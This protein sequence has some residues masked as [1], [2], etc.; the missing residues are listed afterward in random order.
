[1][2]TSSITS[3]ESILSSD[4]HDQVKINELQSSVDYSSIDEEIINSS[5][6][7]D[8]FKIII[9]LFKLEYIIN[10]QDI[11]NS[12]KQIE[13]IFT[14]IQ[15]IT[16]LKRI[17][18]SGYNTNNN[19]IE[20]YIKIKYNDLLTD[21]QF[22]IDHPNYAKFIELI[23][24]KVLIIN[25]IP[26]V[27][28]PKL[29]ELIQFKIVQLY[30]ISD[31]DN[32]KPSIL[33]YLN[34]QLGGS[35][36]QNIVDV[37]DFLQSDRIISIETYQKIVSIDCKNN[38]H[39]LIT[40]YLDSSMILRNLIENNIILLPNYYNSIKLAKVY[41]ILNIDT[42]INIE[43]IIFNMIQLKKFSAGVKIDQIN[44]LVMF[45]TINHQDQIL[46]NHIQ[47]VGTLV[48]NICVQLP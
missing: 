43:D 35:N 8:S 25:N 19:H 5:T 38:Y 48:N 4:T 45:N 2:T 3:I 40:N 10:N 44:E 27:V 7:N 47:E 14:I 32:R 24:K 46:N 29:I 21:Y 26:K 9:L 34:D 18:N 20:L 17:V 15:S 16:G 22:L 33:S 42:S 31:Y 28:Y 6:I 12:L 1:M 13:S 30:L 11:S 23:N 39:N 37:L 41:K 36:D